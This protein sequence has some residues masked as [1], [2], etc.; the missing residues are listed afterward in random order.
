MSVKR[1]DGL[2]NK[3]G[4]RLKQK[5]FTSEEVAYCDMK[6]T[7][8]IHYAGRFAAKEAI[9][10]C[11]LSSGELSQIDFTAI[12]ILNASNGAPIISPIKNLSYSDLKVSIS[13]ESDYAIA[14]AI[15]IL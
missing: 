15:L 6:A 5:T 12:K 7:P 10:K 13:H 4:D 2:L 14:M 9:K 3:L 8:A 1:V 11:I